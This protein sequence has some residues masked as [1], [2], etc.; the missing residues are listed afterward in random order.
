MNL[1]LHLKRVDYIQQ[2]TIYQTKQTTNNYVCINC[3]NTSNNNNNNSNVP[4]TK[5]FNLN[6]LDQSIRN[7][8]DNIDNPLTMLKSNDGIVNIENVTNIEIKEEPVKPNL[9]V[10][11]RLSLSKSMDSLNELHHKDLMN[12]PF[13]KRKV[14]NLFQN[15]VDDD[16][17]EDESSSDDEY[18]PDSMNINETN[19]NNNNSFDTLSSKSSYSITTEANCDFDFYQSNLKIDLSDNIVKNYATTPD[20]N[21]I[22]IS[23]NEKV[24]S[25]HFRAPT[26][27]V[28]K[29]IVK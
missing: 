23:N 12:R 16:D 21:V 6:S 13:I 26:P 22:F 25:R 3:T 9:I 29:K 8:M 5:K 7:R 24:Q 15:D 1:G 10:N 2:E 28:T 17:D 27:K 18:Y 4:I 20:G 19:N 14:E 11:R